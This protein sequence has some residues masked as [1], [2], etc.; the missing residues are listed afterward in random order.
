[1]VIQ[2]KFILLIMF[3]LLV[4]LNVNKEELQEKFENRLKPIPKP[5]NWNSLGFNQKIKIYG[6]NL[7]KEHSF[8]ADKLR[9]KKYINDLNISNLKVPKLIKVLY[10]KD[11]LDLNIAKDCV[12]KTNNG[13]ND[14]I[15]IKNNKIDKMIARAK[16]LELKKEN[17]EY[18]KDRSLVP[19]KKKYEDHYKFIK[20]EILCEEYLGDNLVD[21]K[22]Y[23]IHGKVEFISIMKDR[24]KKIQKVYLDKNLN[25]NPYTPSK[26][27]YN[28]FEITDKEKTKI[29]EMIIISERISSIFEFARI[30][31]Y[32][33]NNKIYFGEITLTPM[34]CN[35]KINPPEYDLILGKKWH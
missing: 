20:P 21:Y 8:F 19:Q 9:V 24:F 5:N 31:L 7:T 2:K 4:F 33:I 14:I 10:K 30:D 3:L 27:K 35:V 26:N 34:A 11:K 16:K 6:L 1:M 23:C 32:L 28:S 18:W 25:V 17:Y 29:K 22:F 15:I 13:W 12:I